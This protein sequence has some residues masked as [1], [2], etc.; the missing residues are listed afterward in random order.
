MNITSAHNTARLLG[1]LA[2]MQDGPGRSRFLIYEGTMPA[3]PT[4]PPTGSFLLGTI[5]LDA[6]PGAIVSG[7]LVLAAAQVGLVS[8]TGIPQW[9]RLVNP[10][11]VAGGDCTASGVGGGGQLEVETAVDGKVYLGGALALVSGVFT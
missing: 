10:S 9:A 4:D 7:E 8:A 5:V 3:L 1:T 2:F 6:V 11:D